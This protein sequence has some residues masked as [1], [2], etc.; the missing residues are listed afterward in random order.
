ML[1]R[2]YS[3]LSKVIEKK[4]DEFCSGLKIPEGYTQEKIESESTALRQKAFK[5]TVTLAN[6][7]GA[8]FY[9][10]S[11]DIFASEFIPSPLASVYM[12][13]NTAFMGAFKS[14]P[15]D[16]FSLLLDFG[17]PP[18]FDWA[19][20]VSSPT[21]NKSNLAIS[22]LDMT[23]VRSIESSVMNALQD[24]R[25]FWKFIH[26]P[27][28]YDIGL[29][30]L[31]MPYGIYEG[32]KVIGALIK[33]LPAFDDYKLAL[34]IYA[35]VLLLLGYPVL[36]QYVKWVFPL[37]IYSENQD[38]SVLHRSVIAAIVLGLVGN[39]IYDALR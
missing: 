31:A 10:E 21:A 32:A 13:N 33:K 38:S 28:A 25:P 30:F 4:A 5:V 29:W 3:D 26:V 17:K 16:S 1:R 12:T 18:V 8:N 15:Q 36:F 7:T 39:V 6:P 23:F 24:R 34:Y 37:N 11:I 9:D 20:I 14:N 27:F 22:G 35:V 2:I 19:S